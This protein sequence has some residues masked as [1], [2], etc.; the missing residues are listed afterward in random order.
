MFNYTKTL[1]I[2]G[3]GAVLA[4]PACDRRREEIRE[5]ERARTTEERRDVGDRLGERDVVEER[6]DM[7]RKAFQSTINARIKVLDERIDTLEDEIG[8]SKSESQQEF[9][10]SFDRIEK[11]RDDLKKRLD[12]FN[13]VTREQWGTYRTDVNRMVESLEADVDRLRQQLKSGKTS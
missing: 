8:D 1:M 11:S 9:K 5:D 6:F 3:L 12:G 7:E 10:A 2:V 13:D 4:A